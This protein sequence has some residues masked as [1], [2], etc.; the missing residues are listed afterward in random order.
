MEEKTATEAGLTQDEV[1]FIV[2]STIIANDGCASIEQIRDKVNEK[3]A[4][5]N[6]VLSYQGKQSLARLVNFTAVNAGYIY[7]YDRENPGWRI[8]PEGREFINSYQGQETEEVYDTDT[9]QE[10]TVVSN[11][12]LSTAF[13]H[14]CIELLKQIYPYYTWYHQGRHKKNE[15]GLDIIGE[16]LG[17][18]NTEPKTLGIQVKLHQ[19][20]S[21]PTKEEWLKFLA[22]CFTRKIG[23]A[24][25][26]TTGKLN[27]EQRREAGEAD[28]TIIEGK[29]EI[30]RLSNLY[31]VAQF[32]FNE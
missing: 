23:K 29:A 22:G 7:K 19:E 5:I 11:V 21:T 30:I 24:I 27:G 16:R 2:L 18:T 31:N 8:T 1:I 3:L 17:E 9:Q 4:E 28:V 26:I 14:Y 10:V 32:E 25:F 13:E 12:V 6:S 15:R 20:N